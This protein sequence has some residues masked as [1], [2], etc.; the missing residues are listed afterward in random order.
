[1]TSSLIDEERQIRRFGL[2]AFLLFGALSGVGI[3]RQ[4]PIPICL[5]GALA[6]I[7]LGLLLLPTPLK[8]LYRGWLRVAHGIGRGMTAIMLTV[9]FYLVITPTAWLKR[10]FGGRPLPTAPDPER[11]SYWVERTEPTQPRERFYKRY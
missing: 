11:P 8:P 7:G 6:T 1:M 4:R 9:A 10:I 5:F 2:I 3:W